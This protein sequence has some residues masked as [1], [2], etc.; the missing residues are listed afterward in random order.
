M[1]KCHNMK[2]I[3]QTTCGDASSIYGKSENL[4]KTLANIN[5][6]IL[7]NSI[8]KNEPWCFAYHYAIWISRRTENILRGDVPYLLWYGKRPSY[9]H[10][11][12]WGL[13]DYIIN[14]RFTKKNIDNIS[15]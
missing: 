7:L 5:R 8:Q 2:I 3:V 14:G 1:K 11:K 13:R 4:N 6:D 9:K 15:H 10:I 12:I